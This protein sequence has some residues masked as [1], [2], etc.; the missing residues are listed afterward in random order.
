MFSFVRLFSYSRVGVAEG[1]RQKC[2]P[3]FPGSVDR[4]VRGKKN[5][6]TKKFLPLQKRATVAAIIEKAFSV[7]KKKPSL[8]RHC[9]QYVRNVTQ[10][11]G[12]GGSTLRR[13]KEKG[14][15]KWGGGG[16][17]LETLSS[18][19][20][21]LSSSSVDSARSPPRPLFPPSRLD[22]F[23]HA[24]ANNGREPRLKGPG[25]SERERGGGDGM[26][27]IPPRGGNHRAIRPPI[28]DRPI[29]RDAPATSARN[30]PC[31]PRR[32]KG[33]MW[34]G[35]RSE[36]RASPISIVGNCGYL[37]FGSI[38]L[39][40]IFLVASRWR[41]YLLWCWYVYVCRVGEGGV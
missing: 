32:P 6:P 28:A 16:R 17:Q 40:G 1:V 10:D 4:K 8:T 15:L 12:R 24:R 19:S 35:G 21:I 23:P 3:I 13:S 9:A 2:I 29:D 11:R 41:G 7:V 37:L 14:S 30:V 26:G 31:S 18:S 27:G 36:G 38:S 34:L 5:S 22:G 25:E 33:D 20:P 39:W